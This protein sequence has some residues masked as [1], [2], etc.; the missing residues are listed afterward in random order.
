MQSPCIQLCKLEPAGAF[1]MG[2]GRSL[3][4]LEAWPRVGDVEQARIL[5]AARARLAG[6]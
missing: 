5:A 4:E 6:R 1:C 2:C 3:A